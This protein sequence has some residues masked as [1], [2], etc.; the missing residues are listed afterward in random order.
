[1]TEE[2]S[3]EAFRKK[4]VPAFVELLLMAEQ[5]LAIW[6]KKS[7]RGVEGSWEEFDLKDILMTAS[8]MAAV[9]ATNVVQQATGELVVHLDPPKVHDA[10]GAELERRAIDRKSA[11]A[12][13][14]AL[15]GT[16]AGQEMLKLM[17]HDAVMVNRKLDKKRGGDTN[18]AG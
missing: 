11:E 6:K 1:M 7:G 13:C 14:K 5:A 10:F 18:A 9:G 3:K 15:V 16:P 12:V 17:L 2:E 8:G 4:A